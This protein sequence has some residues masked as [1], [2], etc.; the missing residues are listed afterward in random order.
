MDEIDAIARAVMD[1]QFAQ[2]LAYRLH[3]AGIAESQPTD[4]GCNL[5]FGSVVSECSQPV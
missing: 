1:S 5:R 3:V 4:T 2:A